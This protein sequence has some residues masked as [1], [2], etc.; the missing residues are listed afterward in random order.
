VGLIERGQEQ[1]ETHGVHPGTDS[2]VGRAR[3]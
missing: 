1:A 2:A 3:R